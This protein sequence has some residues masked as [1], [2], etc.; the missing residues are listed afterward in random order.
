MVSRSVPDESSELPGFGADGPRS[1]PFEASEPA[2]APDEAAPGPPVFI[3]LFVPYCASSAPR[4][5]D[6][7]RRQSRGRGSAIRPL[8]RRCRRDPCAATL[9]RSRPTAA[10]PGSPCGGAVPRV[11]PRRSA[12]TLPPRPLWCRW[13]VLRSILLHRVLLRNAG[14]SARLVRPRKSHTCQ[15]RRLRRIE[16]QARDR[17]GRR[18]ALRFVPCGLRPLALDPC[19]LLVLRHHGSPCR[20]RLA[21][22]RGPRSPERTAGRTVQPLQPRPAHATQHGRRLDSPAAAGH[23]RQLAQQARRPTSS[24]ATRASRWCCSTSSS[25]TAGRCWA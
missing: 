22:P 20:L 5:G 6:S 3:E 24:R 12:R 4:R 2:P 13:L 25:T 19:P 21:G 8:R 9:P 1:P 16:R 7:A 11:G 23:G 15:A 14:D 18:S 17:S 10:P